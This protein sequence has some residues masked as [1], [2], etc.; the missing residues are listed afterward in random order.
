MGTAKRLGIRDIL[1]ALRASFMEW[2][3]LQSSL[4]ADIDL[5]GKNTY[6]K[7][8]NGTV[9]CGTAALGRSNEAR[10]GA[11]VLHG[12]SNGT[13]PETSARSRPV[14]V[15]RSNLSPGTYKLAF[16]AQA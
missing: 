16:G 7:F 1:C 5:L 4:D 10:T 3:V 14:R 6:S 11:P 2:S 12:N 8:G 9:P 13:A 15:H